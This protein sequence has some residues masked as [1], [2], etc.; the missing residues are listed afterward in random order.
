MRNRRAL[1]AALIASM[2]MQSISIPTTVNASEKVPAASDDQKVQAKQA[3]GQVEIT[4]DL[5]LPVNYGG[6]IG[7]VGTLT[8]EKKEKRETGFEPATLALAR[9]YSTTEPLAHL[10]F[11]FGFYPL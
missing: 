10:H 6:S 1:T 7:L 11:F 5:L 9:R 2:M 4:L 8:N 3:V